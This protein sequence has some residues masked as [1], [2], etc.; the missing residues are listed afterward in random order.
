[1]ARNSLQTEVDNINK[2]TTEL[3]GEKAELIQQRKQLQEDAENNLITARE[4]HDRD[5]DFSRK[6]EEYQ[7]QENKQNKN[8]TE[9]IE[10]NTTLKTNIQLL[11]DKAKTKAEEVKPRKSDAKEQTTQTTPP[12]LTGPLCESLVGTESVQFGASTCDQCSSTFTRDSTLEDH[13]TATHRVLLPN[14]DANPAVPLD[15]TEHAPKDNDDDAD[16]LQTEVLPPPH[17]PSLNLSVKRR[18]MPLPL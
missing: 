3:Q 8:N 12:T 15:T 2:K 18:S 4:A 1:M 9:I 17:Q 11:K 14:G 6:L 16:T 13:K 7:R 5:R 10:E